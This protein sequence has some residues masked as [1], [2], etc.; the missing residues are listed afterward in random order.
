MLHRREQQEK[1]RMTDCSILHLL[2]TSAPPSMTVRYIIL[3]AVDFV[4]EC[5]ACMSSQQCL[6]GLVTYHKISSHYSFTIIIICQ[7]DVAK[8]SLLS[9]AFRHI[10][11]LP[12]IRRKHF[13]QLRQGWTVSVFIWSTLDW[14]KPI[15][16]LWFWKKNIYIIA[17][18]FRAFLFIFSLWYVSLPFVV[19]HP[20]H[21]ATR[22]VFYASVLAISFCTAV[23]NVQ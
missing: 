23:M 17:W 19:C 12:L 16:R 1:K 8:H 6:L 20:W 5:Q 18:L 3:V 2:V 14:T 9:A 13:E 10:C 22:I 15:H 4:S 11:Q 7:V 21:H